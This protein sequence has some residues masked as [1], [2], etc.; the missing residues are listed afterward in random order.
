MKMDSTIQLT[1]W[2]N[3]TNP[4]F[5]SFKFQ[6]EGNQY[7]I[8]NIPNSTDHWKSGSKS[9]NDFDP[10][11]LFINVYYL[12]SNSTEQLYRTNQ[13]KSNI[14]KK[15]CFNGSPSSFV[16]NNYSRL[17]MNHTGYIQYYRWLE[18]DKQ[19]V[20][21][22]QMP[23][24]VCGKFS[25]WNQSRFSPCTCL[26]GYEPIVPGDTSAGCKP[27]NNLSCTNKDKF[28]NV[29]M[30]K[31]ENPTILFTDTKNESECKNA[32]L[33]NCSYRAYSFT[34]AKVEA[35]RSRRP[36]SIN[37]CW[38][39]DSDLATLQ[40]Y[41]KHNI[42]I[43]VS[44]ERVNQANGTPNA[45]ARENSSWFLKET[46]ILIFTMILLVIF[47]LGILGYIYYKRVVTSEQ[48][49]NFVLQ[50]EN[51]E[52]WA[53]ELLDPDQSRGEDTEGIGVPFL[54]LESILAATDNFSEANKLGRGGFGPVY[55]GTFL[56]G[57]EVA[58]KRLSSVSVQG[59]EEFRNEVMLIAKLQHRNLV[60]LLGY[61]MKGNEKI[62]VYE[63]MSNKSL[64]AFIFG[65]ARGLLYL[66]QDSRLRIIHRDLKTSNILLDEEL[67]PKISDFGLAKI[68]QGREME[69]TTNRVVGTYGYMAPEYALEGFF[70][71][72]SDV[73]SFGVV[74]LEIISGKRNTGS[75]QWNQNINL[76]G[77]AWNLWKE[78]KPSEFMDQRLLASNNSIEVLKC[79]IIGLLC[80]QEDPRDRPSM[81]NVV[82]MLASDITSLPNPKQPAFVAR[83]TIS[84][85]SSS[86]YKPDQTMTMTL[87][88]G[89]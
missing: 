62:L 70:S 5:G 83:R 34:P 57:Q 26:L 75:P 50:T 68:V 33:K 72:K 74:V 39:W 43:R 12:L 60:R 64:D 29:S 7:A 37:S 41:G 47:F 69:A 4:D 46:H 78:D 44:L 61:C 19:W 53:I 79:I 63:Y 42:S 67:N 35:L 13:C 24:G 11:P 40:A 89:R 52:R 27:I 51:S 45:S 85:S 23:K 38:I 36:E 73:Y 65:I 49:T 16:F 6:Q 59:F 58:V 66:H 87:P 82:L 1:S 15:L 17:L 81:T 31:V 48:G 76:I 56:G 71:I 9:T 22:W 80:V 2:K 77:Y 86:S 84:S 25:V 54:Q 55:K 8:V 3:V 14:T 20:L 30:I 28:I 10:E 18:H 88:E 21:D 32:C